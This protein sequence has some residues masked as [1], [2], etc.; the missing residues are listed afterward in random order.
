[1]KATS[2]ATPGED[3]FT[4]GVAPTDTATNLQNALNTSLTRFANSELVA[5][6][7]MAAGA[8]FFNSG[9][10]SPP[11]RVA[12]PPFDTATA[13]VDG[14]SANTVSWY[15]GD[16]DTATDPRSTSIARVDT[17]LTASYGARANEEALRT[18]MQNLA[19]FAAAEFSGSDPN[20]YAQYAALTR[21]LT[22]SLNGGPNVQKV[23]DIGSQLAAVQIVV[24]NAKD[25]HLQSD[26]TLRSLLDGIEGAPT[27]EVA[28]Q[29]LTLQTNL[30]ATLQTTAMLLQTNIL[31]YL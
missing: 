25:R 8:D 1:M 4:I 21:R 19:V 12:G 24:K 9:S 27:E 22:L 7:A 14:T 16:D 29:V 18:T 3:E 2:S 13:L 20:G 10:S 30:Q 31:K 17:S 11:K 26:M 5:A 15:L 28:A 6:S 23:S